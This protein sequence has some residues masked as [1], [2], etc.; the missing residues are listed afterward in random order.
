MFTARYFSTSLKNLGAKDVI[1]AVS[2]PIMVDG[3]IIYLIE[4]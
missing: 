3:K 4:R 1:I 2:S